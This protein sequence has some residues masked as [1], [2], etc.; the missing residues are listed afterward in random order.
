MRLLTYFAFTL[1]SVVIQFCVM[2]FIQE[3]IEHEENAVYLNE[4]TKGKQNSIGILKDY[5]HNAH[6]LYYR[7]NAGE[8]KN[9]SRTKYSNSSL[10]NYPFSTT[11]EPSFTVYDML[12]D[13]NISVA[14][15][16]S[17]TETF[18]TS[19]ELDNVTEITLFE[20]TST[21]TKPEIIEKKTRYVD[22]L[23]YCNF[24]YKQCD[25]NCCCD[26]DCSEE[27]NKLFRRCR[28]HLFVNVRNQW[29]RNLLT[30]GENDVSGIF[31]NLFCI[32]KTNLPDKRAA[33][34][35]KFFERVIN[36]T[37]VWHNNNHNTDV[38]SY[39]F[40]KNLYRNGDPVWLLKNTS[41]YYIDFPA[42]FV[43]NYCSI[44]RPIKFLQNEETQ[45]LVKLM[46]L[47]MFRILK[48]IDESK[49]INIANNSLNSTAMNCSNL[50]C[51]N[52]TVIY[53][54]ED[55]C[56]D[57]NKT[58]HEPMCTASFC[59]N[60]AF[61]I[62]YAFYVYDS[63]IVNAT[64][65]LFAKNIPIAIQYITQKISV[66]FY[67][68]NTSS[69]RIIKL[70]GTPGYITGLPIITS[71]TESNHTNQFF[72]SDH[73]NNYLTY[74]DNKHGLCVKT[75]NTKKVLLFG[76]NKRM[77]CKISI[78][79]ISSSNAT[80]ACLN[81][82]THINKML[83]VQNKVYV[84]PYGNPNNV[85]DDDWL[86]IKL[87]SQFIYGQLYSKSSKIQCYNLQTRVA[88]IFTYAVLSSSIGQ[89][90]NK[91]L[92]AKV[93]G[94]ASNVTFSTNSHE[95]STVITVD[96]NFINVN[97]WMQHEYAGPPHLNLNLPKNFFFPFPSN[98]ECHSYKP[99][100][101]FI[102]YLCII[103]LFVK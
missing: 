34:P 31:G 8:I 100:I 94:F 86:P 21:T 30:C 87:K 76:L 80:E 64:V 82:Q 49:V 29:P 72:N 59:K 5:T 84:S 75:K 79:Y 69:E 70:S 77:K 37:F 2:D 57:F 40:T 89:V 18:F 88:F 39:K 1:L 61:R 43:N 36:D 63:K 32:A 9:V 55:D 41:I 65:K 103:A 47:E 85:K 90:E 66:K 3:K 26:D 93:D 24:M 14:D 33:V 35:Q 95:L 10:L 4:T 19:T 45:C 78:R 101:L 71:F 22:T 16:V 74:P 97:N 98:K 102:N 11:T 42:P 91:L 56:L 73:Q 48:T 53:C 58:L 83:S 68:G 25:I 28:T 96:I 44:R 7:L 60:I 15:G 46:E 27:E 51:T 67:M 17:T 92:S 12:Y 38:E 52:W 6:A 81:V 99:N 50:H 54:D 13:E 62:E 20:N 23:C